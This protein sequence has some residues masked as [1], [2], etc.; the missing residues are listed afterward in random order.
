LGALAEIS[1]E[2]VLSFTTTKIVD[3]LR[4]KNMAGKIVESANNTLGIFD[5]VI[6]GDVDKGE[7]E[8]AVNEV[9][10]L[11]EESKKRGYY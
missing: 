1:R 10:Q 4:S 5:T 11:L 2:E 3:T 9:Q 8:K 7:I 6:F